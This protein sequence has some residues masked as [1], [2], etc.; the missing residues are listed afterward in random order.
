MKDFEKYSILLCVF[1]YLLSKSLI[2]YFVKEMRSDQ[3]HY[4][5]EDLAFLQ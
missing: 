5:C 2:S 1:S 4:V 3:A